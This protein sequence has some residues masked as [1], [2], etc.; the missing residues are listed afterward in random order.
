MVVEPA[1]HVAQ[2]AAVQTGVF[3]WQAPFTRVNPA[4]Q[5][6]QVVV[7]PEAHVAQSVAVHV[8][9]VTQAPLLKVKPLLHTEHA[10]ELAQTSQLEMEHDGL[11]APLL[12]VKPAKQV[13]Q[14]VVEPEA[15]VAQFA[16][17]QAAGVKVQAPL[18]KV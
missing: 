10:D 9:A 15:Q 14:V 1:E 12:S 11:Q 3:F 4:L 2:F 6:E 18:L 5:V 8:V 7:E 13:A 16:A 17:V